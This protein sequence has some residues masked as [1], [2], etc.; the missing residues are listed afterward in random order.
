[1]KRGRRAAWATIAGYMLVAA[2][3]LATNPTS[4][5]ADSPDYT[6]R[7]DQIV[8]FGSTDRF[9]KPLT[10]TGILT[11]P[12]GERRF[13]AV[14]MLYGCDGIWLRW[15]YPWRRRLIEWGY[16]VFSVDSFSP[17]GYANLCRSP[18]AQMSIDRVRDAHAARAFLAGLS[19]VDLTRIAVMGMSAGGTAAILSIIATDE[20]RA[21]PFRAA[22]AL[23]P[24][25]GRVLKDIEAPLLVLIAQ[26]DDWMPARQCLAMRLEVDSSHPL[27]MNVIHGATHVFDV[28]GFDEDVGRRRIRYDAEATA[29]AAK[30]MKSF[31]AEH[32]E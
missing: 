8:T 9:G 20:P 15:D 24:A 5:T 23:Y 29:D 26:F 13:P 16:V 32:L 14:V 1:M 27:T 28:E 18:G 11:K 17:R 2:T 31:L 19:Y 4:A 30:Q 22:V 10:L 7:P 3:G 25:C 12:E 21:Y 6:S